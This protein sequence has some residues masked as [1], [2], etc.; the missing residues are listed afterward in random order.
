M[1]SLK[2]KTVIKRD[3]TKVPYDHKKI[4]DAISKANAELE[5]TD[6]VSRDYIESELLYSIEYS[7]S[8][9]NGDIQVED[10]QDI[11]EN[12]I[13]DAKLY[14]LAKKYMLYR[15][16][17]TKERLERQ[18]IDKAI[19]A[20]VDGLNNEQSNANVDELSFG[21]RK[22]EAANIYLKNLALERM[23]KLS[24]ANHL[25]NEIYI[26]DL[27]S[28]ALGLHNC[29][30]IPF[31]DLLKNGFKTRQTDIRPANSINTAFQLLAVIFQLQSLQQFGGCSATH[32]DWTMIPFVRKSYY[33]HFKDGCIYIEWLNPEGFDKDFTESCGNKKIED[34]S[35]GGEEYRKYLEDRLFADHCWDRVFEY[36]IDMT[37]RELNQSVEAMYHNLNSL[38]SRSGNQ[39]ESWLRML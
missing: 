39:L 29:L 4:V 23:S 19:K 31:D 15:D 8:K 11:V 25:N 17:H 24:K 12:R 18:L 10:I 37:V 1:L 35:I 38:Q 13:S 34:L 21:G 2:D 30:S 3:G 26:H 14:R 28:Y 6:K 36:A 16:K 22:G 33:K 5:S 9:I 7:L 32:I 27:D 20:K